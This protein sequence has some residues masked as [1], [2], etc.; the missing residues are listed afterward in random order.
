MRGPGRPCD[1]LSIYDCVEKVHLDKGS[2]SHF[3]LGRASRVGI[4]FAALQDARGGQQLRTVAERGDGLVGV[5]EVANNFKHAGV[6]AQ[7]LWCASAGNNQGVVAGGV[8]FVKGGVEH[9][10]VATLFRV[11]LVAL[12]IVDGSADKLA[13]LF[14][15]TNGIDLVTNHLQGLKWNHD[16]VVFNEIAGKQQKFCG[17]HRLS[18]R[19]KC[20]TGKHAL[21]SSTGDL[22]HPYAPFRLSIREHDECHVPSTAISGRRDWECGSSMFPGH[23]LSGGMKMKSG[24]EALQAPTMC[25]SPAFAVRGAARS[26][27]ASSLLHPVPRTAR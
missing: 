17:F 9:K 21:S 7:I 1:Q 25:N 27:G 5:V 6:E 22:F 20:A 10:V 11:G 4:E 16:L 26:G 23:L 13:L 12:E 15:G 3:N 8:D 24:V 18:L 2:A 14:A 19:F